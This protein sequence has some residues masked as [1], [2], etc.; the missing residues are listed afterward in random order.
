MGWAFQGQWFYSVYCA[1]PQDCP[2]KSMFLEQIDA[3][4]GIVFFIV[5]PWPRNRSP[6]QKVEVIHTLETRSMSTVSHASSASDRSNWG[7]R[8]GCTSRLPSRYHQ[9]RICSG[10]S[11][12]PQALTTII[13]VQWTIWVYSGFAPTLSPIS[14]T[15][16]VWQHYRGYRPCIAGEQ[17]KLPPL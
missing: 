11:L 14:W 5:Q 4:Q 2:T 15:M 13:L 12:A 6:C 16:W 7:R 3:M 1:T 9:S 10:D 8:F 17:G